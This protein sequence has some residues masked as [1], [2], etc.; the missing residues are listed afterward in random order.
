MST[1]GASSHKHPRSGLQLVVTVMAGMFC[2]A[3]HAAEFTIV[4][5]SN[6]PLQHLYLSPCGARQWGPDQF[7]GALPPSRFFTVSG[8]TPGC[9]DIQ[10]VVA[11]W[12]NCV[13]AGASLRRRAVW[14]VTQWTVFG[15]QSGDCSH[16][17]GYVPAG[18]Q[19]WIWQPASSSDMKR[20]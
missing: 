13:I 7:S 16:V 19:P 12:N 15:S 10:F 9:Y 2:S 18:R 1:R 11:P 5:A 20:E 3:A 14:K 17:A 6:A 4:N 8:I